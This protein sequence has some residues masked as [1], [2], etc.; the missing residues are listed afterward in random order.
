MDRNMIKA[1]FF[2]IDGTLVSFR[3]HEISKTVLDALYSLKEKGVRLFIASGRHLLIMDNL[4]GFPF[5][6]Y[7]C[8]NGSLIYDRGEVIYSHPLDRD[9]ASAVIDLAESRQIP[10]VLFAEKEMVMNCQTERTSQLF[11]MIR[12]PAPKPSSLSPYE[13]GPVCQFTIF[14]DRDMEQSSLLPLLKHSA[15]T[16]WHPEFTDIVPE[17]ISKAE[18]VARIIARYGIRQDEVMAFGDGGND[19]EMLEYAGIGVAMGNA[20]PDVQEHADYVAASV[21]DDGIAQALKHFGVL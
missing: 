19:I 11:K 13:S 6:G 8:M 7:V 15:T 10:C 3:T 5:D 4:S 16:R 20:A 14:V 12:L 17:N 18:G 9:D 2:D 1:I 21:D